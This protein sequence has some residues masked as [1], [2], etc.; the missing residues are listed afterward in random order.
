MTL[1][2]V[3]NGD[4]GIISHKLQLIPIVQIVGPGAEKLTSMSRNIKTL[5]QSS[6]CLT[7]LDTPNKTGP[8]PPMHL[9]VYCRCPSAAVKHVSVMHR[10]CTV[11]HEDIPCDDLQM[12]S[13]RLFWRRPPSSRIDESR[14][15]GSGRKSYLMSPPDTS[16]T[17]YT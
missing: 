4:N 10:N 3:C 1:Y 2:I 17:T 8:V 12:N 11:T 7:H 9:R 13:L 15:A 5:R 6:L 14:K 16:A